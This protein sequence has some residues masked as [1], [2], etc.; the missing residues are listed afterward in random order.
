MIDLEAIV[1][2]ADA[3][4]AVDQGVWGI[5]IGFLQLYVTIDVDDVG[6]LDRGQPVMETGARPLLLAIELIEEFGEEF[7]P[8]FQ[9]QVHSRTGKLVH[10]ARR[11]GLAIVHGIDQTVAV[12]RDGLA[13]VVV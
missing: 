9:L 12:R 2:T 1:G 6:R 8:A 3:R 7:A 13:L 5:T 4:H 11:H 10:Q